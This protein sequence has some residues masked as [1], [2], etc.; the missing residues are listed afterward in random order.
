MA[1]QVWRYTPSKHEGTSR[2]SQ[3]PGTLELF[4]EP[5]DTSLVEKADNLTV[6]PWGD[7]IL[8][9]DGSNEQFMVGVTPEGKL[10]KFARN[11][12]NH[13]EFAGSTF[14]PDGSTLFVNIQN[15]GLTLA[16]TGPWKNRK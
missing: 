8:C 10:Y 15:P 3:E 5:N 4:V 14:S 12:M 9:E 11:V 16:I 2:E 13:S 6:T 1:G 7:L